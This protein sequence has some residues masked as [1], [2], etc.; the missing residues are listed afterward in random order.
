MALPKT[1]RSRSDV[2][3]ALRESM[4]KD[5]RWDQGRTF[6]LVYGV[7]E[8]HLAMLQEAHSLFIAT[9]GLGA[10]GMFPSLAQLEGEVIDIARDLLNGPSAA[11]NITSGGSESILMGMRCARERARADRPHITKPEMIIARSAHPAFWKA[12]DV[13]DL[14]PV[15]IPLKADFSPDLK[16]L[17]A[18][19]TPNTIVIAGSAPNYPFG[20]ID[21]ISDMAAIAQRHGIHFHTDAC[22]GGFS[23][24]F[25]KRL[26]EDIPP[27]D[28]SVP[29]VCTISA[30]LHKYGFAARGTSLILYRDADMQNRSRFVLNQWS[31]GPY[32]TPAMAGSRPGGVVA[33]AWAIM[34]HLG[35]EGYLKLNRDMMSV[36]KT[37]RAG[38]EAIPGFRILGKPAMHLFAAAAEGRDMG[39]IAAEMTRRGWFI[40]RQPTEPE[41]LHFLITPIHVRS[42]DDLLR[43]LR[44]AA[45]ATQS[46]TKGVTA[47]AYAQ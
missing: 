1:G 30:D 8:D 44:E 19:I 6:F 28:F 20:T 32:G 29:G 3:D 47:A 43:D 39:A 24:P 40:H 9:N 42:A 34:Q 14:K 38:I 27:F 31:G 33:A 46:S 45:D 17:E 7:D 15:V 36:T 22:V 10:G 23:L 4:R 37:L 5:G 18:A 2:M 35:E 26:G 16:A 12:A 41:S 11:G 13:L 25:L 21:P